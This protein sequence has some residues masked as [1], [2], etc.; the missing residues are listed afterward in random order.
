MKGTLCTSAL[1]KVCA[2]SKQGLVPATE[3]I[4]ELGEEMDSD[5]PDWVSAWIEAEGLRPWPE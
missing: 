4:K 3:V 1:M 2:V 5:I